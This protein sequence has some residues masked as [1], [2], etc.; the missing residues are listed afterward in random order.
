MTQRVAIYVQHLLGAGHLVRAMS[1][2][3]S[4]SRSGHQVLLLSGGFPIDRAVEGYQYFQLPPTCAI[5]GDFNR[6]VDE[7]GKAVDESW[8][9]S[10]GLMLM[11]EVVKF[12]PDLVITETFPFGRRQ[13]RFELEPLINWVKKQ[14]S[15]RLMA[16]IRDVLQRRN[17]AKN[18]LTVKTIEHY[19]DGV[20][21]HADQSL[22]KLDAS[23]PLSHEIEDKLIYTGYIHQPAKIQT[24]SIQKGE[25]YCDGQDEI[26]VSGGSGTVS[27]CLLGTARLARPLSSA[28]SRV[29]RLLTG[30]DLSVAA[31]SPEAGLII[32]PNRPDFFN[33]LSRCALSVSQAGYNTTLDVLASGARSLMIPFAGDG[34]TEQNDRAQALEK[35]GRVLRIA[36]SDLTP[37]GLARAI[38][39]ALEMEPVK[40]K[41]DLNGAANSA[42]LITQ[43]LRE[44]NA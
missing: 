37:E 30:R 24:T 17:E 40:I 2:A 29:W 26:I 28:K 3:E 43:K 19:Y 32:E 8:R 12:E 35:A 11:A 10:R 23:F 25:G 4:L 38:D 1:L 33:L 5:E 15:V 14:S 42:L 27:A 13:F 22:F 9:K 39:R 20:L 16:S 44:W 36:E 18:R 31:Q 21:V 41:A 34:E 7:Y 6:L